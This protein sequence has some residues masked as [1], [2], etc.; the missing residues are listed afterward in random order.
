M[1]KR[2]YPA[3]IAAALVGCGGTTFE[4]A[5]GTGGTLSGIDSG[6]PHATG[7]RNIVPY[8]G[9]AMGGETAGG[10]SATGGT[11]ET[12]GTSGGDGS[13][14]SGGR[15]TTGGRP[16]IIGGMYG[17]MPTGGATGGGG[18][19]GK[20]NT[21]GNTMGSA[22]A[23]GPLMPSGG[24]GAGGK[25]NIGGNTMGSTI[26]G[27]MPSGGAGVGGKSHTGGVTSTSS[28]ATTSI[29]AGTPATGGVGFTTYYGVIADY[30]PRPS[31]GGGSS[32]DL[33][34]ATSGGAATS[35]GEQAGS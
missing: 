1:D 14:A 24:A 33:I 28:G 2:W 12:G 19:G 4:P 35:N 3:A 13:L 8:Y 25:S 10:T 32:L 11:S 34:P 9:V 29:D 5:A 20:P 23:Y 7:G 31:D 21:G 22:V 18:I 27:P 16:A 26:Y 15:P 6:T 17:P 30:G